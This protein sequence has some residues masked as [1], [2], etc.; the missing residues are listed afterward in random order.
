MLVMGGQHTGGYDGAVGRGLVGIDVLRG[1]DARGAKLE[2]TPA[3]LIKLP[4]QLLFKLSAPHHICSGK[5]TT[6]NILVVSCMS[7][8]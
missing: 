7:I 2:V 4:V 5:H 6:H 1:E 8:Q 3:S